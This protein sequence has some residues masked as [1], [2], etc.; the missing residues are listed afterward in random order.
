L[1]SSRSLIGIIIEEVFGHRFES[2]RPQKKEKI[3]SS[4]RNKIIKIK[5]RRI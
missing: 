2:G 5:I 4:I 3:N 1:R